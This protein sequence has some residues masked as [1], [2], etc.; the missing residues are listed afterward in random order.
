MIS[1]SE[2]AKIIEEPNRE[3]RELMIMELSGE[4]ARKMLISLTRA[5]RRLHDMEWDKV[6][7]NK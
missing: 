2:M 7:G 5:M 1:D 6:H 4:E 3:K